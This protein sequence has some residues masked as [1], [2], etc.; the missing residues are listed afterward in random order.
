MLLPVMAVIFCIANGLYRL[1]ADNDYRK[2]LFFTPASS[3]D[4]IALGRK[5]KRGLHQ[6]YVSGFIFYYGFQKLT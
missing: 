3:S 4:S 6:S 2:E 1:Y 5:Y